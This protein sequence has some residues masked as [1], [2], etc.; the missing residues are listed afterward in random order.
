[1]IRVLLAGASFV[2]VVTFASPALTSSGYAPGNISGYVVS[3]VA[4][5]DQGEPG[6]VQAV[7]LRLDKRATK[8]D[9][10]LTRRSGWASCVTEGNF[11][12][13]CALAGAVQVKEIRRLQVVASDS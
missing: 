1:M 6:Q 2:G 12:W 3:D 4:Y 11:R 10:R 7:E 8:V 9:V 5:D 13:R